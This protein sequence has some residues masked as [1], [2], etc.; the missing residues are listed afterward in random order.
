M[1]KVFLMVKTLPIIEMETSWPKANMSAEYH[2]EN[3]QS[4]TKKE[5]SSK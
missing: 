2:M 1:S 3:F 4:T 5:G